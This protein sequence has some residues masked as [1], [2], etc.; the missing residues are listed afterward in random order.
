MIIFTTKTNQGKGQK[1][2]NFLES[3]QDFADNLEVI[4]NYK[5]T[6]RPSVFEALEFANIRTGE[7]AISKE[8]NQGKGLIDQ[9]ELMKTLCVE[10]DNS[11]KPD[12]LYNY[13]GV[14]FMEMS[15]GLVELEGDSKEKAMAFIVGVVACSSCIANSI[16]EG[17]A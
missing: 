13:L 12:K 7:K 17:K 16:R 4:K 11:M 5:E 6:I 10:S 9:I 14:S 1:V 3:L 15:K 2:S 8:Q